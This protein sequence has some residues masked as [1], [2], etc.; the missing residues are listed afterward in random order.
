VTLWGTNA[1]V[2]TSLFRFRLRDVARLALYFLGRTRGVTVGNA[3]LLVVATGVTVLASEAVLGLLGS[4]FVLA[5]LRTGRPLISE[6]EK[7]FTA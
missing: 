2:I 7:E 1:L 5:L 3:C 6:I 4:V